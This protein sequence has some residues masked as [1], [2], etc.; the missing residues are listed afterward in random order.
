MAA[1]A[2]PK[3]VGPRLEPRLPLGLQRVDDPC[4]VA[5]VENHG[6]SERTALAVLPCFGMYT[7]LTGRALN[8]SVLLLHPVGQLCL[9]L[10][11]E[12]H[13]AIHARRQTTSVAL[14][15]PPHAHQRVG[16]R[17]EHQLLQTADPCEVPRL[18]R[19]EDPLPQPPYV[20]LDRPPV[21]WRPSRGSRPLVR[22]PRRW[23]W[24]PT[25]PSVPGLR[26]SSSLTGSPDR[27]STL[28]R[29]GTRPVSGRLCGTAGWRSQP[30]LS[31]FPV[32]FRLPAFRFSVIRFPPRGWALL[33]VGLPDQTSPDLD[34]VT[35]FR[36]HE[37]RPGWVPPVPRG[38][39]CSSRLSGLPSRRLPLPSGQSL[40]PAT[41]IPSAELTV[42]RHQR[43]FKFF[44]RPVFPSPVAPGW[45]GRPW[46]FPRA[47]NPAERADDA[48]QAEARPRARA[49]DYAFDLSVEPPIN[50]FTPMRA[51]SRRTR[52]V[53]PRRAMRMDRPAT[54]ASPGCFRTRP[55]IEPRPHAERHSQVGCCGVTG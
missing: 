26:S 39:R 11:G 8:G 31:R 32:A 24:R 34:G 21:N 51:T 43:R 53:S 55:T 7:R 48:R 4:L 3:P 9:G 49:R 50:A 5:A 6:N 36:T 30:S 37:L 10:R 40:H 29:P 12:H 44:T 52:P 20:L 28:S 18:R 33:T 42:T 25:C 54:S 38:R 2:G 19:R 17:T 47:S 16:A 27:V 46:A 1:T 35:T 13:L 14:R 41:S 23:S 15:H 22:S 45:N